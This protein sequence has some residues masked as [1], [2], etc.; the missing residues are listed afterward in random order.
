VLAL[1]VEGE[2]TPVLEKLDEFV[3]EARVVLLHQSFEVLQS[4]S[5]QGVFAAPWGLLRL[6]RTRLPILPYQPGDRFFAHIE[7][8]RQLRAGPIPGFICPHAPEDPPKEPSI[9]P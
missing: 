8:R 7:P 2:T 5:S 3:E 1:G 4:F 9:P 6:K